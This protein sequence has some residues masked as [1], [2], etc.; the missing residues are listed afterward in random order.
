VPDNGIALKRR[1]AQGPTSLGQRARGGD[2]G[3]CGPT[4]HVPDSE[5]DKRDT[6]YRI[7]PP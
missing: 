5:P 2:Q 7:T 6:A 4:R 3:E 1:E